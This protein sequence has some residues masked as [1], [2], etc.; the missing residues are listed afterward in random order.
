MNFDLLFERII[1]DYSFENTNKKAIFVFGRMN[2][3]TAGHEML[4]NHASAVAEREGRELFVFV[5][6]KT[7]NNKN[8]LSFDDKSQLL[9]FVFP[10]IRIVDDEMANTPFNAAYWLRDHGFKDVKIVAGSDRKPEFEARFEPYLDHAD[11]DKSFNFTKFK[12]EVVGAERDP[13]GAGSSGIS[14]SKARDLADDGEMAGFMQIL[15]ADTPK[16]IAENLY[17]KIREVH[18]VTS[19]L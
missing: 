12:V 3:P 4:I 18:N 9:D 10:D 13:D 6:R 8:P 5:S 2:P 1:R 15:P 19:D 17:N 11:E 16:D 7:D 14:A